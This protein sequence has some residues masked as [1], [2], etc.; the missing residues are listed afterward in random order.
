MA[1]RDL[2]TRTK[3]LLLVGLF[4]ACLAD[5]AAVVVSSVRP[6]LEESPYKEIVATKD[7]IADVLPPPMYAVEPYLLLLQM[8]T[9]DDRARIAE[10]HERFRSAR[11]ELLARNQ[12]WQTQL[13]KNR[14]L[15][16]LSA[17]VLSSAQA[18]FTLAE[19]DYLPAVTARDHARQAKLLAGPLRAAFDTHRARVDAIVRVLRSLAKAQVASVASGVSRL[20]L[21]L[22]LL[23]CLLLLVGGLFAWLLTQQRIDERDR[24]LRKLRE[25]EDRVR[26]LAEAAFEGV[27]IS[28]HGRVID[29]N[30]QT[31]AM[32]GQ[33]RSDLIGTKIA[34][35][36][37]PESRP[38][39]EKAIREGS[40]TIY[41]HKLMRADGSTF[42]AEARARV[43]R[44]GGRALRMT[45]IRDTSE[46][47]RVE[48]ALRESEDRMR[49][50]SEASFEGVVISE[51]ARA[52]D[53]NDQ[54]LHMLGRTREEFIG[55]E[56]YEH[57][58]PDARAQLQEVMRDGATS[59]ETRLR[60]KDGSEFYA[61]G[62]V[63]MV[64]Q[65]ARVL[66]MAAV[67]DVTERRRVEEALRETAA[68]LRQFV[69]HAPA[70]IAMLDREMRY[71]QTSDRWLSE[72]SLHESDII[73]KCHYDVFPRLNERWKDV[74]QRVLAGAIE[75][76]DEDSYVRADGR[77]EWVQWECRPWLQG[78]GEIGG[79]MLF[80]QVITARKQMEASLEEERLRFRGLFDGA[81]ELISTLNHDGRLTAANRTAL[82]FAG[83]SE[84]E[85]IGVPFWE[86]PWWRHAPELQAELKSAV[87]RAARGEL[88]RLDVTHK[89]HAGELHQIDFSLK[90]LLLQ[91]CAAS[92][93]LA[94]GRDVTSLRRAEQE[95]AE[96][97]EQLHQSQKLESVGRLAGGIA[98]DFNNLLTIILG[99][100]ELSAVI[101]QRG[102]D[103][104]PSLAQGIQ[105]CQSA[106]S[107]TRQL[108]MFAR[109]QVTQPEALQLNEV[110]EHTQRMLQRVI[111]ENITLALDLAPELSRV[112]M[113][114]GHLEQ[115]IMNL[116]VNARD[117]MPAGGTVTIRTRPAAKARVAGDALS[118]QDFIHVEVSDTGV[119]MSSDVLQKIFEPFFTTKA[120]GMGTGIGLATVHSVVEEASGMIN[121][122]SKLGKGSTF[123]IY[124]PITEHAAEPKRPSL[125]PM[126]G[127][128]ERVVLV[129]DQ[130]AV[131]ALAVS[132][133]GLLGYRVVAFES[134][135]EAL[136]ALPAELA[137]Y[138]LVITDVVLQK[139][140]GP[141]LVEQLR[142]LHTGLRVL[143]MSGYT[144]AALPVRDLDTG[145]RLLHKPF[146][147]KELAQAV[148]AA[149][150]EH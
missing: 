19:R 105:A 57:V 34:D 62:R 92:L 78:N 109:K 80:T 39:V 143:Y 125:G 110:V 115:L 51:N 67:R 124:L 12:Y 69:K 148:R 74:L 15:E 52:L 41:E 46:R 9:T 8:S 93:L 43:V 27:V 121:V 131:R 106:A 140:S 58:A 60:R 55:S 116:V 42:Y 134:A 68:L 3:M 33:L 111:G 17:S 72:Y 85:V 5:F 129:E 83:V 6:R 18:F 59:Y 136:S 61:E 47:R 112:W 138:Q 44:Q 132:Q 75:R 77:L 40:E 133:L 37:A 119:G 4:T 22:A 90:P 56:M 7:L 128:H 139:Q 113:D 25:S 117:A 94:E 76:S 81:Y 29:A 66:R 89:N 87:E 49:T 120:K 88:V 145:A 30:D 26:N 14:Q 11:R 101:Q 48:E 146:S 147:L 38:L 21:H 123:D 100:L 10:L 35:H 114:R 86:G 91:G 23:G 16:T 2:S 104:N 70:A 28:E 141:A 84:R 53:A 79:L 31:L 144:D 71:L 108:L 130:S 137:D 107:L 82:D 63:R 73:G 98:H 99:Q 96:L 1:I 64:Q 149:L 54:L 95:R 103:P 135:E 102:E 97:R 142:K 127:G 20:R 36:V 13:P 24:M 126:P 45:A 150:D 118:I 122:R 32:L 65:G 50:L